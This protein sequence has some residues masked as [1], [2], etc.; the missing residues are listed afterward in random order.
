VRR[1][2]TRADRSTIGPRLGTIQK[3]ALIAGITIWG[4]FSCFLLFPLLR[5]PKRLQWGAMAL[6]VAE[7]L[8]LGVWSYGSR[9]CT[10]RPCSALAEA[11]RTAAT[12]DV[13][14]LALALLVLAVLHVRRAM[15]RQVS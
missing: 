11:G 15:R 13:P 8:A 9:S 4:L 3:V 6:L 1:F 5:I 12:I 2:Q 7:L 14:L 10:Q